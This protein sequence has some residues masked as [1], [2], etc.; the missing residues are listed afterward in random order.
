MPRELSSAAEDRLADLPPYYDGDPYIGGVMNA[1]ANELERINQAAKTLQTKAFPTRADNQY[2]LLGM[3]EKQMGL[4]VEPPGL[5][6][7][8]R[9]SRVL[10]KLRGRGDGRGK[11]WEQRMTEAIGSTLWSYQENT[12]GPGQITITIPFASGEGISNWIQQ[13]ARDITPANLQII[14]G[15]GEGFIVGVSEVGDAL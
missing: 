12:P 10:S 2:R 8:Q 13:V 6:I 5:T 7:G 3:W 15:F 4:P 14:M 11:T 1:G 9:R